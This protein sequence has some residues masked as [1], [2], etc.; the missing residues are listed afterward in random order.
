MPIWLQIVAGYAVY[1]VAVAWAAPGFARARG[2]ALVT[3]AASLC[4]AMAWPR[5][6]SGSSPSGLAVWVAVPGL[7][8]LAA[9]RVSGAF[10]I[11]PNLPLERALLRLDDA[12]LVGTGLRR[13]YGEMAALRS[14]VELLYLMVYAMVPV[15]AAVL[16]LGRRADVLELYWA[17]VFAAELACYA[18][19]PWLQTRPPRSLEGAHETEA[20]DPLRRL[21][22]AV[23]QRGSI[24]VNT[25]PSAHAA[26]AIAVALVM[27]D[28][29]PMAGGV[30]LAVALG[31]TI[32]T[33]LGR[34]HYLVDAVLGAAV[35]VAAWV[36]LG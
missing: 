14:G 21:N 9:Y 33:V 5:I 28:A 16:V 8:L 1:L 26:G 17:V 10:F 32:A 3:L 7:F 34:Y 22:L 2:P 19:L 12:A 15:G 31:I 36:V 13:A 6:A 20:A 25:L 23:L 18:M 24:Q 29:L 4:L 30:F 35:G 11:S 27:V